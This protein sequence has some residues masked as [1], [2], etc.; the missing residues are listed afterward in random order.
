[1]LYSVN[2]FLYSSLNLKIS[3]PPP[4]KKKKNI[5]IVLFSSKCVMEFCSGIIQIAVVG[6]AL[7]IFMRSF[8]GNI[9]VH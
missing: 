5:Y 3:S 2:L 8:V 9:I 6:C 7:S 1:M 4:H